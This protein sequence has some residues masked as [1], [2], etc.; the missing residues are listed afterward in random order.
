MAFNHWPC[1]PQRAP[2]R[3]LCEKRIAGERVAPFRIGPEVDAEMICILDEILAF[4]QVMRV[5]WGEAS[6]P[7]RS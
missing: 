6:K 2:Q 5:G 4:C 7:L 3:C 1:R